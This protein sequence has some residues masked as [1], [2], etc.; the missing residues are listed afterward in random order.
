MNEAKRLVARMPFC[1]FDDL[2]ALRGQ[3]NSSKI[4]DRDGGYLTQEQ[5]V[6]FCIKYTY[7]TLASVKRNELKLA[8]ADLVEDMLD[9]YETTE[10]G[11]A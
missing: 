10:L 6:T 3:F 4:F 5:L 8:V 2:R 9:A 11:K 1:Y 7:E